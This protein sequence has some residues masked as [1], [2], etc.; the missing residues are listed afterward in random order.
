MDMAGI[1]LADLPPYSEQLLPHHLIVAGYLVV[2][3]SIAAPPPDH[4]E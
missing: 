1:N 2:F 4:L 3:E